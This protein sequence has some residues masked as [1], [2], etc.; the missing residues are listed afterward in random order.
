ME[1]D[2]TRASD[3]YRVFFETATD[4]ILFVEDGRLIA[5]NDSALVAFDSSREELV[6]KTLEEL[7]TSIQP[8]GN[9]SSAPLPQILHDLSRISDTGEGSARRL[10]WT[11][12]RPDGALFPAH[13]LLQPVDN[14]SKIIFSLHLNERDDRGRIDRDVAEQPRAKQPSGADRDGQTQDRQSFEAALEHRTRQVELGAQVARAIATEID[15]DELYSSIVTQVKEQFGYYH[16]QLL[17]YDPA[18]DTVALIAGYGDVGEK[19]LAMHHS[20]PMGVGLIGTAAST[21]RSLLRPDISQD[22]TWQSNPLLPHTK[23]ELTVPIKMGDQVLGVFDVQSDAVGALDKEDQLV[24]EGLCGQIAVAIESTRLR[25]E[26][27]ARLRELD[28]LQR[29]MSREGWQGFKGGKT[30]SLGYQFGH[31]GVQPLPSEEEIKARKET[32]QHEGSANGDTGGLLMTN[33]P[34][35]IVNPLIVRGQKFGALGIV[36]D[37][38]KPLSGEEKELLASISEQVAEALE[39]ARLFEQTQA[40]LAEQERLAS[41]LETVAQVSAAAS[42]LLDADVLLQSVVDL[43]KSSFG[44]YHAHVF[45]L[46]EEG[47][48]LVLTAGAGSIGRLMVLEGRSI[49]LA[50]DS[51]VARAARDREPAYE[52]DVRKSLDFLPNKFLPHTRSELAAPMIVGDKLIGVLDFQSDEIDHFALEDIQIQRTLAAQTAVAVQNAF[53][54]AHQVHTAEKL[55]QVDQLKSEFLASMSHELRTPLNSIIGFADVLL[56]GLDGELNERMEEDVR[57]IRDSGAHLRSLIGDILDMTKIEAGRME[58]RYEQID[59][60]Q[61]ANEIMATANPL[62]QEKGIDLYLNI[63]PDVVEVEADRTRLRQVLWNIVGNAIK[64]TEE[65]YVTLSM[66]MK[67]EDLLVSIRD[68]GV[69]IAPENLPVVF[70]QFRQVDGSL[71][72]SIGGTGLGMPI[73]KNLVELH[74][75]RIWVESVLGQGS[76]FWFSLPRHKQSSRQDSTPLAELTKTGPL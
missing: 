31:A 32:L 62:A 5:A 41:Q 57:L 72:R 39:V 43:A 58:L 40:S 63:A 28:S 74:G 69:G 1:R 20:V 16:A 38:L 11:F 48:N 50:A 12:R 73:S 19:M 22:N 35:T 66:K 61:I 9:G 64:F 53:Q 6:G 4:P 47:E 13:V 76:T 17:R 21:G 44:L 37:P 34:G 71:N 18:L 23:G 70:E 65:G 30:G 42:T 25:Q 51:L 60:R 36:D 54:Y 33:G 14:E 55:R 24:L 45:L 27:A 49:S 3:L 59:M 56:E 10:Q 75:G 15:L 29:H 8:D 67:D 68:T 52:N 46:D 26:M 7:S 2:V